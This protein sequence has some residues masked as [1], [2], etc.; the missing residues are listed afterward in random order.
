M[1]ILGLALDLVSQNLQYV[2]DKQAQGV[3]S[4]PMAL[5]CLFILRVREGS[6]AF[7][8]AARG[9]VGQGHL[10]MVPCAVGK[11]APWSSKEMQKPGCDSL[12]EVPPWR[13]SYRAIASS[14]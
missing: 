6:Q 7:P 5:S 2:F 3:V 9:G 14:L 4:S 10:V 12:Q 8:R 11:S 13:P 1:Q